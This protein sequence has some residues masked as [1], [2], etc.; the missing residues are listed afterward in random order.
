[1]ALKSA[2]ESDGDLLAA[3]ERA[4]V[5]HHAEAL[6][7]AMAGDDRDPIH[8]AI[9]DLNKVSEAFAE[10][11]MDRGIRKALEGKRV[12]ELTAGDS[13]SPSGEGKNKNSDDVAAAR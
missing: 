6:S 12:A 9:A 13:S 5:E 3:T 10:R 2:L 4:E 1:I 8:A 11:R 7:A